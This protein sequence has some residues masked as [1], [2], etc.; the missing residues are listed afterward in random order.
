MH[1]CT[2]T[3]KKDVFAVFN[4]WAVKGASMTGQL[5]DA[6]LLLPHQ[7]VSP[8]TGRKEDLK[9]EEGSHAVTKLKTKKRE[10]GRAKEMATLE[11]VIRK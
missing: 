7:Q 5:A 8:W 4:F 3:V 1:T 10:R 2:R 11:G 9:A 6:R